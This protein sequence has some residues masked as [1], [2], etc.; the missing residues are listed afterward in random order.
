MELLS[1]HDKTAEESQRTRSPITTGTSV[2]A[3]KYKDGVMMMADTLGSYGGMARYKH[4][5]RIQPVNTSTLVGAGGEYS[6]WQQIQDWLKEE[7]IEDFCYDDG[8]TQGPKDVYNMLSRILYNRRSKNDPLWNALLIA[9]WTPS[10]DEK[11][12]G[13][14]FLGCVDLYGSTY[15]D[16]LIA[17]GYGKY[18]AIPLLRK[19]W[20]ADLSEAEA[21]KLLE[22][23]M[24]VLFYR[25][26]RTINKF[27]LAKV[28]KKGC[29][30]SAPYSLETKWDYSRFVDPLKA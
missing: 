14:P 26:C 3:V 15:Q 12:E 16:D 18:I 29:E 25:D 19:G 9:G 1:S 4:L 17:T 2:L 27:N 7:M 22:D 13:K 30:I 21:K 10:Q 6:D 28:T 11:K 23:A 8:F 5:Q 24:R 20:K